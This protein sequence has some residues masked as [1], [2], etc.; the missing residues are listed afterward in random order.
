MKIAAPLLFLRHGETAW[1][2]LGRYQGTTDTE[3]SAQ[4][5]MRGAQHARL[6]KQLCTDGMLDAKQLSIVTSPLK[7]AAATAAAL[8]AYFAPSPSLSLQPRLRELSFGRWEGLTSM[9]VEGAL[10]WRTQAPQGRPL[11]FR[12]RR[13]GQHGGTATG[14]LC[15]FG[16]VETP[17][18]R[19]HPFRY[20]PPRRA[21]IERRRRCRRRWTFPTR[22]GSYGTGS[23]STL[24]V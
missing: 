13:W 12:A 7:R 15:G 3:L 14:C 8:Q 2:A 1:N 23:G 21:H 17:Y 11:C 5:K 4:G 10:L 22:V 20:H 16:D 24:L 9:E 18:D 19:R 6:I